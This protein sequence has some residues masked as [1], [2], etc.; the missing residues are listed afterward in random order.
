MAQM[1]KG[2]EYSYYDARDGT[3]YLAHT[4]TDADDEHRLSGG[5]LRYTIMEGGDQTTCKK[6][7]LGAPVMGKGRG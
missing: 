2:K 1:N 4:C 3:R 7:V 6:R 5:D